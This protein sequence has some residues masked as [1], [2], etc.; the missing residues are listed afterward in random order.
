MASTVERRRMITGEEIR[1]LA[2]HVGDPAVSSVYLDADGARR[3]VRADVEVAFD[4]LANELKRQSGAKGDRVLSGGVEG[5][6][7]RMHDWLG[8]GWDRSDIRGLAF[9]SD[10][11]RGWFEVVTLPWAVADSAVLGRRPRIAPLLAALDENRPLLVA[12]IDRR[13]L[14][15]FA[16]DRGRT[17]ELF[18]LTDLEPRAVDTGNALG[19]F[20]HHREEEA[21]VHYRRAAERIDAALAAD[22]YERWVVGGPDEAV[23][24]LESQL[25]Q[26]VR[27]RQAGRVSVRVSAPIGEI[28]QAA[29]EAAESVR[30]QRETEAVRKVGE[31]AGPGQAGSTGLAATLAALD[32][33]RVATLLVAD[34]FT[35]PGAYCLTCGYLGMGVDVWRCPRCG[36]TPVAEDDIVELAIDEAVAQRSKVEFIRT[37][38]LDQFGEIAAV[39][40][41][42]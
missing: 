23:A 26:A 11:R 13:R 36:T 25:P 42:Q 41:F 40:R 1:D 37:G 24:G 22:A 35:A 34:G 31:L 19:R 18:G 39:D 32:D 5:D 29:R 8:S 28:A 38:G 10:S 3:P 21:R 30:E 20:E 15:L 7:K 17:G 33:R 2:A 6:L 16:F 4:Y 12:L 27:R 9:F 14:R